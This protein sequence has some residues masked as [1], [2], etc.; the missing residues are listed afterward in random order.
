VAD[1]GKCDYAANDVDMYVG[2]PLFDPSTLDLKGDGSV[3]LLIDGIRI[4]D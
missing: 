1:K 2:A 4:D 3:G